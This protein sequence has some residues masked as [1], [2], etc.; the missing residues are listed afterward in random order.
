MIDEKEDQMAKDLCVKG[1]E[2]KQPES[3]LFALEEEE[4]GFWTGSMCFT[5]KATSLSRISIDK[6]SAILF[7][8]E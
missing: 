4:G 2:K 8:D 7:N 1:T 6:M 5:V 3:F